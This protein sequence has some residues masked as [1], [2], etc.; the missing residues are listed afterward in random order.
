[1]KKALVGFLLVLVSLTANA[2]IIPIDTSNWLQLAGPSNDRNTGAWVGLKGQK[3]EKKGN[4]SGSLVSDFYLHGDFIFSGFATPTST[5]FDDNDIIGLV[6]GWQDEQNHYRLGWTQT[7]R[8]GTD[9]DKS[10][11]DIT[12]R[13]GLFLI[14]EFEGVSSTLF[15]IADLFWQ[16]DFTYAF[17]ISRQDELLNILFG[18]ISFT[19]D[20]TTF[21]DGRVG[22]Y[23][24]SQTAR[25]NQLNVIVPDTV[26]DPA[27]PVAKISEPIGMAVFLSGLLLLCAA[28][29]VS[30]KS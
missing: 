16:D 28:P 9:D 3:P 24:E 15:N 14:Q 1:M 30:R 22:V 19:L 2:A 11:K 21:V 4:S 18:D 27:N 5:E 13:T 29:R 20:N 25:F 6:F 26:F 12:G 8:P 10:T 23:T 17:E 7:Q